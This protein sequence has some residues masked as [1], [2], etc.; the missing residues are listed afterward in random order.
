MQR[1]TLF[2][3][4]RKQAMIE[5]LNEIKLK[6]RTPSLYSVR[7]LKMEQT[8]LKKQREKVKERTRF[9]R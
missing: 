7:K 4:N 5:Q 6:Q 1:R 3:G 8:D 2:I 9:F